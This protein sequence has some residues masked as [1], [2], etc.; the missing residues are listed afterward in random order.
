MILLDTNYLIRVLVQGSS[1]SER[2]MRWVSA[3]EDLCTSSIAWYEFLCGPVDDA[4][5]DLVGAI[6]KYRIIPYVSD[7][8]VE[9][10]RLFNA[11]GRK[12]RLRVDSMIA[13]AAIVINAPLAT[14]NSQ[15]FGEFISHG[16][17]VV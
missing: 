6:I 3:G 1:E 9:S 11:T 16:L 15:D 7:H 10:S 13:A 12:R 14:D 17:I 4:G 5:V 8:A 2:I